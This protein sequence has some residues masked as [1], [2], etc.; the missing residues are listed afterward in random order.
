[1]SHENKN[2]IFGQSRQPV[3]SH[4]DTRE[5]LAPS[6]DTPA[7]SRPM[8][9]EWN[10]PP[11]LEEDS[12]ATSARPKRSDHTVQPTQEYFQQPQSQQ[13]PS[14]PQQ[15]PQ[16]QQ[17]HQ[18]QQHQQQQHA[19]S[20]QYNKENELNYSYDNGVVNLQYSYD[21]NANV[22]SSPNARSY[23]HGGDDLNTA[24]SNAS[25][26]GQP[27]PNYNSDSNNGQSAIHPSSLNS[28]NSPAYSFM[29]QANMTTSPGAPYS[30]HQGPQFV[31]S[32]PTN[33]NRLQSNFLI[34]PLTVPAESVSLDP[35]VFP[36][37]QPNSCPDYYRPTT[38]YFPSS[39]A[40]LNKVK[41]PLAA[42]ITPY[43]RQSQKIVSTI[44]GSILRCRR[45][46]TYMNPFVEWMDAGSRYRCN[47]CFVINE[48]KCTHSSCV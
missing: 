8:T 18:H 22:Y 6:A 28:N 23:A 1:M 5:S 40:L 27:Y 21:K 16:Y 47:L 34:E 37:I 43:P 11:M 7:Y 26:S 3:T 46:R 20:F 39:Q 33:A 12:I 24:V 36:V 25:Y 38:Q 42:V 13:L 31:D 44:Q 19:G 48:G 32:T 2:A 14:Y 4:Q 10:D 30:G 29:G 45:C 15:Q 35:P 41:I 9:G 17:Q